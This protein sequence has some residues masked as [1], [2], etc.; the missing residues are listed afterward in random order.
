MHFTKDNTRNFPAGFVEDNL[1]TCFLQEIEHPSCINL[2]LPLIGNIVF[3]PVNIF[4]R[5][6][7][8]GD[9]PN[10]DQMHL[11]VF[12]TNFVKKSIIIF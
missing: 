8:E 2:I 9:T 10:Y 3:P 7:Y 12:C 11:I 6:F 5:S 4:Q 1:G